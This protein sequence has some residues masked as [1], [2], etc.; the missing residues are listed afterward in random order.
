MTVQNGQFVEK[1]QR[2]PK[3]E[4]LIR[5]CRELL[6]ASTMREEG[7]YSSFRVCFIDPKS[8]Y[9]KTYIYSHTVLFKQ[10]IPFNTN[11]IRRLAPGIS[12]DI[13]YLILDTFDNHTFITGLIV[14][15]TEWNQIKSGQIE[16][17]VRMPSIANL[18]INGPGEI[19]ACMGEKPLVSLQWG[20]LVHYRADTFSSTY[21]AQVLSEGSS[22]SQRDRNMF[23]SR[24]LTNVLELSHGGHIYIVPD[25]IP[26]EKYTRIKYHLPV[27][28]MFRGDKDDSKNKKMENDLISYADL[29][30]MF[31]SV[32]GAVV[33]NKNLDLLGFGAETL[34]DTFSTQEP[35]MRFINYDGKIDSSKHYSDNGMRHRACYMFC[36][37]VEGAVALI[38]S[39]D[40]FIKACTKHDG[41]VIVYD[42]VSTYNR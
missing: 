27:N 10:P 16:S 31:T 38:I 15:Y 1:E 9:L 4:L 3:P 13:S 26:H 23:L 28:F 11:A 42:S 35:Y 37:E 24:V 33:L 17:G 40:G 20:D 39:H 6:Y 8:L 21:I 29:V 30:S 32:D 12:A 7:R 5:I 19:K 25:D 22:V 36:N 41:K 34:I 14:G 18:L 2:F